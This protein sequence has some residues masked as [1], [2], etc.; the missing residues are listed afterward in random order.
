MLATPLLFLL[1][2]SLTCRE[3]VSLPIT[4]NTEYNKS[5]SDIMALLS[6]YRQ[7]QMIQPSRLLGPKTL[8]FWFFILLQPS[9]F[10]Q[11]CHIFSSHWWAVCVYPNFFSL[12]WPEVNK[13]LKRNLSPSCFYIKNS[14]Q[15]AAL[16]LYSE[17][18]CTSPI[19]I[20]HC[21]FNDGES[22]EK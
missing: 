13:T 18:H 1:T 19:S 17:Y 10:A 21:F 11:C 9:T 16:D 14:S 12:I 22:K 4:R 8:Q 7:T 2:A 6:T 15:C 3:R 20:Y 5:P